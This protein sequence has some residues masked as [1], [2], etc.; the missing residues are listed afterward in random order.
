M[1]FLR[2]PTPHTWYRAHSASIVDGY[3]RHHDLV[4]EEGPPERSFMDV[5]LLRVLYA[6]ALPVRPR[7]ALGR[8]RTGRSP[9]AIALIRAV[10]GHP[11]P[12]TGS[13]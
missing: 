6:H 2:F 5:A 11:R 8:M 10:V 7:L 4:A 3:L 13:G 9:I 1:A 12:L